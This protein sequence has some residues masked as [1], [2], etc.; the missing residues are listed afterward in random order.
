MI[1]M[2]FTLV[3]PSN[4]QPETYKN[5]ASCFQTDLDNPI[6]LSGAWEVTL[7][8]ISYVNS[9][10]TFNNESLLLGYADDDYDIVNE[11]EFAD[12]LTT[13]DLQKHAKVW[14]TEIKPSIHRVKKDV[15]HY[16][17]QLL[18]GMLDLMGSEGQRIKDRMRT[19]LMAIHQHLNKKPVKRIQQSKP[20]LLLDANNRA[21]D[22]KLSSLVNVLNTLAPQLWR[23]EYD[24]VTRAIWFFMIEAS[25]QSY[26][27]YIS[28]DLQ[29]LLSLKSQ[30]FVPAHRFPYANLSGA[31][32]LEPEK[33]LQI[34][35]R[36]TTH[37][38]WDKLKLTFKL[39]P[40]HRIQVKEIPIMENDLT[41]FITVS[42][43]IRKQ[44]ADYGLSVVYKH[45]KLVITQM[46]DA[47]P[48]VLFIEF[49]Q[50]LQEALYLK[51]DLFWNSKTTTY[52]M[53][54]SQPIKK[55]GCGIRIYLTSLLPLSNLPLRWHL[56]EDIKLP[57]KYYNNAHDLCLQLNQGKK[58]KFFYEFRYD[59][60]THKFHLNVRGSTVVSISSKLASLLGFDRNQFY[61]NDYV[62]SYPSTLNTSIYFF[63]I[64]CN[65]IRSTQVG[66]KL[67]PL[68]RYIPIDAGNYGETVYKEFIN[69]V[70]VPVHVSRLRH[71]EF[72]IYD[73]TGSPIQF[74]GGRTV[75]T[76]HFRKVSS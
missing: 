2:E 30:L 25:S 6:D 45:S 27:F 74:V 48:N 65:F 3:F 75:L 46:N 68:L 11:L 14:K 19:Q 35:N 21:Y 33:L 66:G 41:S 49:N 52:V 51:Q 1:I 71:C 50:E 59:D 18:G 47:V 16:L 55:H 58:T 72:E 26:G 61:K 57:S 38:D 23:W 53:K 44:C 15:S 40:F 5:T 67:V 9:M 39:L 8:D 36:V 56:K 17:P 29:T 32:L 34:S 70:Y 10:T 28:K 20:R 4:A 63:Y 62:A 12:K 60:E 24:S 37:A 76:L 7:Q 31:F 54:Q 64:Y 69:K 13:I 42:A 73:D 43:A 22:N